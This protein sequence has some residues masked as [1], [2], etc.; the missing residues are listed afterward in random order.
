MCVYF[1]CDIIFEFRIYAIRKNIFRSHALCLGQ[2]YVFGGFFFLEHSSMLR[3]WEANLLPPM[4]TLRTDKHSVETQTIIIFHFMY[5]VVRPFTKGVWH[6][7]YGY[8]F[9]AKPIFMFTPYIRIW[10]WF[11][12][13]FFIFSFHQDEWQFKQWQISAEH[14]YFIRIKWFDRFLGSSIK[15]ENKFS[16]VVCV[17]SFFF[18]LMLLSICL[19]W[20]K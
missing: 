15:M 3:E 4:W 5:F 18:I 9:K 14:T 8:A 12:V 11:W 10:F 20:I 7:F 2:C 19:Y 16:L 6:C 1:Q 17:C 13:F